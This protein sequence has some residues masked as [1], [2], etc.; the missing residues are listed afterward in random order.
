MSLA[1]VERDEIVIRIPFTVILHAAEPRGFRV[2]DISAF[3][4]EV[5]REVAGE[6]MAER[7]WMESLIED[8]IIRAA[9]AD[10]PGV[11]WDE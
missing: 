11:E 7:P 1:K 10:A 6:N 4:P 5:A 2:T 8:A 9:E 3:A